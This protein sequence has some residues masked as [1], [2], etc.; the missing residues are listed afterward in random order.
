VGRKLK[1][2]RQPQ[3]W[4]VRKGVKGSPKPSRKLEAGTKFQKGGEIKSRKGIPA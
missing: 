2:A 3:L 1:G 4:K